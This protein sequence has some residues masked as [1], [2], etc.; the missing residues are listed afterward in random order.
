MCEDGGHIWV[1][2][3][4]GCERGICSKCIEVPEEELSQLGAPNVKFKCVLCHWKI[5]DKTLTYFISFVGF[6]F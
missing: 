6:N 3:E 5:R 2:D 4:P 1:C